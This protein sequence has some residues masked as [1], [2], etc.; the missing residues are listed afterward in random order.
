MINAN[1]GHESIEVRNNALQAYKDR[2]EPR[3]SLERVG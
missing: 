1:F 3:A 2:H